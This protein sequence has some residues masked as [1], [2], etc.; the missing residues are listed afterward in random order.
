MLS[1]SSWVS[2][3]RIEGSPSVVLITV[4]KLYH[5]PYCPKR[6]SCHSDQARLRAHGERTSEGSQWLKFRQ[7]WGQ[8]KGSDL[9]SGESRPLRLRISLTTSEGRINSA[10]CILHLAKPLSLTMNSEGI[11][12]SSTKQFL[13]SQK[14][15]FQPLFI[16]QF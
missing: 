14:L 1:V 16:F 3:R 6:I 11:L 7:R 5:C 12:I 4:T 13:L 10:F 2:R 9:S 8:P 15:F